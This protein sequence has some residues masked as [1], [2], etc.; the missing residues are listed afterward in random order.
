MLKTVCNRQVIKNDFRLISSTYRNNVDVE[1]FEITK[2]MQTMKP[3]VVI[4]I[5]IKIKKLNFTIKSSFYNL[6]VANGT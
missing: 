1:I 6:F 4:E 3:R 2:N 5:Q